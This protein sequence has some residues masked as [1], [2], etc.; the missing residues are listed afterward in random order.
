MRWQPFQHFVPDKATLVLLFEAA[1]RRLA[2]ET[3]DIAKLPDAR[4]ESATEELNQIADDVRDANAAP[5]GPANI[6]RTD[7]G[8]DVPTY[9]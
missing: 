5:E 6:P 9:V 3:D 2:E 7:P 8:D 1:K 4:I